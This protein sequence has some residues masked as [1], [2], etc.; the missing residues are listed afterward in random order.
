MKFVLA[1]GVLAAMAFAV[2]AN[3]ATIQVVSGDQRSFGLGSNGNTVGQSFTAI[4]TNLTSFG[5]EGAQA[6]KR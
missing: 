1:A 6:G 3:A 5:F 4:D 2:P